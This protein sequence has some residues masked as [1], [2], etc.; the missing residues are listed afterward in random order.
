MILPKEAIDFLKSKNIALSPTHQ[1]LYGEEHQVA[2]TAAGIMSKAILRDIKE[3]LINSLEQGIP[4][5][6]WQQK[7]KDVFLKDSNWPTRN[8]HTPLKQ[9]LNIVFQTNTRMAYAVGQ[10]QRAEKQKAN[11]PYAVWQLGP[12][13]KHR[14]EH[15]KWNNKVISLDDPWLKTHYPPCAFGCKCHLL[16]VTESQ[17][18]KVCQKYGQEWPP[19]A[20][21]VNPVSWVNEER[22]FKIEVDAGV[23]PSFAHPKLISA[24][25]R[26]RI[27]REGYNAKWVKR[28]P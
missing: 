8:P 10:A 5:E 3:S 24:E 16:I 19:K 22:G 13:A 20:P 4:F 12:S 1:S 26:E 21:S 18:K 11:F 28:L 15:E 23:H 2:F 9:R 25:E 17:A 6:T 27:I 7:I 14:E